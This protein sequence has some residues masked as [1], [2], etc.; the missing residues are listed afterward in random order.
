VPIDEHQFEKISAFFIQYSESKEIHD[1]R[2]EFISF[3]DRENGFNHTKWC[4]DHV[5]K[6]KKFWEM[7]FKEDSKLLKPLALRIWSTPANSVPSERA[8]SAQNFIHTK[9]RNSLHPNRVDKLVFIDMN[10]RVLKRRQRSPYLLTDSEEVE[11][12]DTELMMDNIL[13]ENDS[14]LDDKEDVD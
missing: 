7:V 11:M 13:I 14:Q 10:S 6:P 8:F 1:L 3:R 2:R 5:D 4:W 12:E 9:L